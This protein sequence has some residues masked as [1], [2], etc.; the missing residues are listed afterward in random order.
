MRSRPTVEALPT[1]AAAAIDLVL[2][3]FGP[4]A[5]RVTASAGTRIVLPWDFCDGSRCDSWHDA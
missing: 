3:R 2:D 1:S 5:L 4:G